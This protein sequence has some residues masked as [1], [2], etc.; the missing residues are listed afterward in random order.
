MGSSLR[1][2]L[3]NVDLSRIGGRLPTQRLVIHPALRCTVAAPHHS[4]FRV[5]PNDVEIDEAS[6]RDRI[7]LVKCIGPGA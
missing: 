4:R 6:A 1:G 7:K 2:V 5:L 3:K